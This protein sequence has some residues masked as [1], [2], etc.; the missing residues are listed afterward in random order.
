MSAPIRFD[1]ILKALK[2]RRESRTINYSVLCVVIGLLPVALASCS[3]S[4]STSTAFEPPTLAEE[5]D[6]SPDEYIPEKTRPTI[7]TISESENYYRRGIQAAV[8]KPNKS[9]DI[10]EAKKW[11]VKAA[12]MKHRDAATQL[13]STGICEEP[14][15]YA[16]LEVAA[17][18]D[19]DARSRLDRFKQARG[20]PPGGQPLAAEFIKIYGNGYSKHGQLNTEATPTLVAPETTKVGELVKIK[21][22][23]IDPD[24]DPLQY[25]IQIHKDGVKH[26]QFTLTQPTPSG[27]IFE[28]RNNFSTWGAGKYTLQVR[29]YDQDA[30]SPWSMPHTIEC[31]EQL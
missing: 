26:L 24:D 29:C 3:T 20:V 12:E 6:H 4:T 2:M 11:Y 27:E 30:W 16:W 31:S 19:P 25:E 18:N 23:A 17:A 22:S 28:Y 9:R 10:E 5:E 21:I 8:V 15:A 1:H 14:E 13:S 7:K